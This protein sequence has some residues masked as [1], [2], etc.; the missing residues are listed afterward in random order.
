MSNEEL[1]KE[2]KKDI[3]KTDDKNKFKWWYI[4]IIVI[5]G[6]LIGLFIVSLID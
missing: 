3:P 4:L 1:L 6:I 5:I 2:L